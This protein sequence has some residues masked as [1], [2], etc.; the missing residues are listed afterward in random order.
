VAILTGPLPSEPLRPAPVR[1]LRVA[2]VVTKLTA[3]AGGI[4]LRGALALDP[5]RFESVLLA[6]AGGTLEPAAEAAGLEVVALKHMSPELSPAA[7][8]RGLR[9]LAGH[10]AGG[11]FDIVHTHSAKAGGIGRIAARRL[12]IPTIVHSLH[13]MPFHEFQSPVRRRA[14]LEMERRLGAFTDYF[15]TDGTFVAAEAVRLRIA[16]AD[17][18]RAIA[19]PVD[20]V[21]PVTAERRRRARAMLGL[22]EDVPVIGTAARLDFQKGPLDMVAALARLGRPDVRLAWIGDG[23]LRPV[24]EQAILRRG[25]EGRFLLFGDRRDVPDLLPGFDAFA[26]SSLYEGLPCSVVEAMTCGVP[27]VATAVNSVP[28][29]VVPGRT[30][31]LARPHDPASLALALAFVLDHPAEARAMAERARAHIGGRFRPQV[32][33]EDLGEAYELARQN[34]AARR[35]RTALEGGA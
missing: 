26:M 17:R 3:G 13:G 16:P 1:R 30:G 14:Y 25:L 33:G 10:L 20:D 31:V 15:L 23:E 21:A 2:Q 34:G 4:T 8:R 27:V 6:A 18:V 7:D 9:E 35:G 19:S 28:E 11:G 32:L 24:V 5:S 12:G 29:I 22:P